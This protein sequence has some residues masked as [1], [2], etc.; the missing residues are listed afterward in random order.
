MRSVYLDNAATTQLREEVINSMQQCL[1]EAYGNPSSVHSFGR[2]CKTRIEKARK[3][4]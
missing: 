1:R 2:S 3:T 4:I